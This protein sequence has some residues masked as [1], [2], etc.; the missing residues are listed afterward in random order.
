MTIPLWAFVTALIVAA[1][2]GAGVLG[3]IALCQVA[4]DHPRWR[5]LPP[6]GK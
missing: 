2:V 1:L 6:M 4:Q 5:G 3:L